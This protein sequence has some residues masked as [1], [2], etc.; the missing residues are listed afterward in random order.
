MLTDE[1][2]ELFGI[3]DSIDI[4][5]CGTVPYSKKGKNYKNTYLTQKLLYTLCQRIFYRFISFL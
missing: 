1:P 5:P 4:F 2:W 3:G